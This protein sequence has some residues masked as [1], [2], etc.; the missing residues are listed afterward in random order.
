LKQCRFR[1]HID[2]LGSNKPEVVLP[3]FSPPSVPLNMLIVPER[4]GV[5]R[6]RP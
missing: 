3:D 4:S 6:V 1:A 5:A 2:L